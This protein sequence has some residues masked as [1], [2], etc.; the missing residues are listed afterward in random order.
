[1]WICQ[2]PCE[3]RVARQQANRP[4]LEFQMAVRQE[5]KDTREQVLWHRKF[6]RT[7]TSRRELASRKQHLPT[8]YFSAYEVGI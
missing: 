5:A 1:M 8:S 6:L 3:A 4:N 2:R 7:W